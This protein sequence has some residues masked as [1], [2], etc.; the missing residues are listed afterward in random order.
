MTEQSS[1]GR[2]IKRYRAAAALSQ[3]ELAARAGVSTRAISDLER[4]IHHTPHA[5][6]LD[7]LITALALSPEQRALVLATARPD[8][9][10]ANPDAPPAPP[11]SQA[12]RP[13]I[14]PQPPSVIVGRDVERITA[15]ALLREGTRRLLTLT[16][17]SGVGKTRLALQI[18]HDLSS[19]FGAGVTFVDLAPVRGAAHVPGAIAQ[20]LG[21][22]EHS[23]VSPEEQVRNHVGDAGMLLV[24]DN[25]EHLLGA[26]A[27]VGELVAMCQQLRVL[28]TSRTPLHLRAEQTLPLAPLAL[29]AAV[30]LFR[31]RVRAVRPNGIFSEAEAAAICERVE[32]LPLTIELV[33]GWTR[34]LSLPQ[35]RERLEQRLP[36]LRNGPQDLPQRQQTMENAVGW[37]YELLGET[38]RRCFRALG[39]FV[40]GFTFEAAEEVCGDGEKEGT[41]HDILH[42]LAELVDASMV[43]PEAEEDGTVRFRLLEMMREYALERLREESEEYVYRR[44]HAEYYARLAERAAALDPGE[45]RGAAQLAVELPNARSALEWA[46]QQGDAEIGLLLLGFARLWHIRGQIGEAI[47]WQERMLALDASARVQGIRTAN[48]SVRVARLYGFARTLLSRGEFAHAEAL[49]REALQLATSADDESGASSALATLGLIAQAVGDL[50]AAGEAFV[51]SLAHARKTGQHALGQEATFHLAE[52]AR[53]QGNVASSKA[54]LEDALGNARAT[55]SAWNVAIMLTMLGHLVRGQ[56]RIAA[57]KA[58]YREALALF[59]AF[60]SPTFMAWLLEGYAAALCDEGNYTQ[61][62]RLCAVAVR[63]REQANTPLPPVE[64]AAFEQMVLTIR[65]HLAEALFLAEWTEVSG[66]P[67]GAVIAEVLAEDID[68]IVTPQPLLSMS[69]LPRVRRVDM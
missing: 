27:F 68:S 56:Q 29:E 54:L 8:A 13:H 47:R 10:M 37:S 43:Q 40:G 38:Q 9:G 21:I 62:T 35:L 63:L 50:D 42:R 5:H 41:G 64:R 11:T 34:I 6:T 30:A 55:G 4:G 45:R 36:L 69:P 46:E 15:S 3:E 59:Q 44:R 60:D 28:V 16:G 58:Y 23:G 53:L 57:A 22:R 26:A 65:G 2:L 66:L 18:A 25:F 17:A 39:V 12:T 20:A 7:A 52:L 32:C 1:L 31:E 48:V 33:A 67:A 14:L 51:E 19:T 61:A 24:L 49:A